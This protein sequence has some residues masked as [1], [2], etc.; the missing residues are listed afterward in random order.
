MHR[1]IHTRTHRP[2]RLFLST[3]IFSYSND[4]NFFFQQYSVMRLN[5]TLFK[6]WRGLGEDDKHS[7]TNIIL[8]SLLQ[9]SSISCF[10]LMSFWVEAGVAPTLN[11]LTKMS[12]LIVDHC[13]FFF[14]SNSLMYSA[15]T[16]QGHK[17]LDHIAANRKLLWTGRSSVTGLRHS[18]L[19]A[20]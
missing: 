13:I 18:H 2:N 3:M 9:F 20:I 4:I 14:K 15:S 1:Y 19:Q 16:I 7:N 10:A 5:W 11:I 6:V 12:N 8:T 17:V